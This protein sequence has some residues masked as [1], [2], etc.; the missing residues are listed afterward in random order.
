MISDRAAEE[1]SLKYVVSV[2]SGFS[3]V[4][5]KN[6]RVRGKFTSEG[7][8]RL[9]SGNWVLTS[10]RMVADHEEQVGPHGGG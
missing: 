1:H 5:V 8:G 4:D 9:L 6:E 2:R 3:Y 7:A 10:A